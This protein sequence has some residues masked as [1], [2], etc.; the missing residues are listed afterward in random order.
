M[1][2][3]ASIACFLAILGAALLQALPAS[4]SSL[5]LAEATL[6]APFETEIDEQLL[7]GAVG[8]EWDD[9]SRH[10]LEIGGYP[11]EVLL[12]HDGEHFYI[13]MVIHVGQPFAGGFE[14]FVFFD[15]GDGIDY[16]SGD[17]MLVVAVSD[18]TAIDADFYYRGTYDFCL[19]AQAGGGSDA[20]GAGL[21]DSSA[22]CYVFEFRRLIAS[23]DARDVELPLGEAFSA[24]Y[25]WSGY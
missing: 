6:A 12:K 16:S 14:A 15:N 11:T 7:D 4:G 10:E 13:A 9:A 25:G 19:D 2:G 23:G 8:M 17:D 21:Y 3:K 20:I 1:N 5:G 18:G 22:G 24:A